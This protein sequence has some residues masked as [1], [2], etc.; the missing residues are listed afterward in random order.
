MYDSDA[1]EE[2][3]NP[4]LI[5]L[6]AGC[7][8]GAIEATATWPFEYIKTQLQLLHRPAK[9]LLLSELP[10]FDEDGIMV[11][12]ETVQV[13]KCE[14]ADEEV[15]PDLP[16]PYTGMISGIVYTVREHGFSAL[17]H[18]LSPTLLG[19]IPKA[20]I[21]FGLFAWFS[22]LLSAW[23]GQNLSATAIY[24]LAG[25][26]AGAIEALVV[27]TPVETIKTK[28]IQLNMSFLEGLREILI[29]EGI[30]GIYHGLV[31]TVLKQGSV[32]GTILSLC[33]RPTASYISLFVLCVLAS[34]AESRT[35]FFVLL[36]VQA[37]RYTRWSIRYEPVPVVPRGHDSRN[38]FHPR[39]PAI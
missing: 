36:R 23:Q 3:D 14:S 18:G 15:E 29:L 37:H 2:E 38:F 11:S 19:S 28:C 22:A 8:A 7:I 12:N 35:S 21:R 20:G 1:I 24:F 31:P 27:V 16:V 26:G 32:S 10:G 6:V 13:V 33:W 9:A 5:H 39:E 34:C 4:L 17:Y 25:L 30:R